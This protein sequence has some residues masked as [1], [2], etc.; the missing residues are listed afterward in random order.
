MTK[1]LSGKTAIITGAS[2][3]IGQGIA[4]V[5]AREGANVAF[6]YC[7]NQAGAAA[8]AEK[9]RQYDVKVMMIQADISELSRIDGMM[10]KVIAEFG[11][12]DVL[13]NN[14]GITSKYDFIDITPEEYD[15]LFNINCRGAF[16]CVQHA[17]RY[18]KEHGGGSIINISSLS[19]RA[20]KEGF[21]AYA[22]TK[23][24]MNK[25]TETAAIELAPYN[26]RLNAV[27]A[28]WVPVGTELNK[29]PEE[30]LKGLYHI[31]IGRFGTPEDIGE[32]CS[33][34]A[35]D[36]AGFITG[37]TIFSDGGQSC[38]LSIPSR[39]R[40]KRVFGDLG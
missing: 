4:A 23:A 13:V 30:K 37:Q 22:A 16:F 29:T 21:A 39:Q 19:T 1:L 5:F 40:E 25:Y 31:P 8:T 14:A 12:L 3:G 15:E 9:L 27:A 33:F 7:G 17:A 11:A 10:G 6:T 32:I 35:S 18:M 34:L 24:A 20:S 26:I 28:G 2:S 38:L 36:R